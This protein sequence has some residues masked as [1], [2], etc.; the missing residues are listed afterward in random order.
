LTTEV[1]DDEPRHGLEEYG[2]FAAAC[3]MRPPDNAV[4]DRERRIATTDRQ[5]VELA[6]KR[7][8]LTERVGSTLRAELAEASAS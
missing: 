3:T 6:T 7:N 5:F 2:L 4:L 8:A 1:L